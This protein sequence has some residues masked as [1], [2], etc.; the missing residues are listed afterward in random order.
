M[1][2]RRLVYN[3]ASSLFQQI[4]TIVCGFILPRLILQ[5][6]GSKVNG[7]VSSVN[8]FLNAIS[9][10]DFGIIAV[11]QSALYVPL[12]EQDNHRISRIMV[13]STRFFR[14]IAGIFGIYVVG[15]IFFIRSILTAN[16][17]LFI[18]PPLL[19]QCV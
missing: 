7:L 14:I 12:A 17:G 18:R 2:K 11:V 15:L 5:A 4:V 19:G 1:R 8:Q 10:L 3:T 6:Y 9:L 13:A 16:L